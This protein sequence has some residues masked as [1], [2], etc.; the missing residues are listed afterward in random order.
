MARMRWN[1]S[2]LVKDVIQSSIQFWDR[3]MLEYVRVK[4]DIV[5]E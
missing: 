4:D 2:L 1:V 5:E 3:A